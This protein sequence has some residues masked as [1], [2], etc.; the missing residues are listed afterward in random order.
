MLAVAANQS[1]IACKCQRELLRRKWSKDVTL[2][3]LPVD[4]ERNTLVFCGL[5][6]LP[7]V[8][9]GHHAP[10][11][12]VPRNGVTDTFHVGFGDYSVTPPTI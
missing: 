3:V 8:C 5:C 10:P 11:V 1:R 12:V 6:E 9:V 2:S 7:Q 4:T